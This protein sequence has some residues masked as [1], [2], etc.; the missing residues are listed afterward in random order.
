MKTSNIFKTGFIGLICLSSVITTNAQEE[1]EKRL[2]D[3]AQN[4]KA[5]FIKADQPIENWFNKA[6]AYVIFPNVGK[7]A[8]GVGAAAGNGIL[9]EQGKPVGSASMKQLSIGAQAGGQAYREIIFFENKTALDRF[10]A[11]NFEFAAQVSAV[12]L[13]SGASL[14]ASYR[15]GVAV[16]TQEKSGLMYEASVGGQKF[17]YTA[18]K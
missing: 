1:K 17:D 5:E 8:V 9:Y 7:G 6:Y 18:F 15:E 14:N 11:G 12:A 3:D 13:T 2:M 16:F 4:A 10:K